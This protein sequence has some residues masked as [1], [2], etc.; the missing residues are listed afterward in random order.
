M[1]K[2]GCGTV[3]LVG[4]V[5]AVCLF[6]LAQAQGQNFM[7]GAGIA[8]V[9]GPAGGMAMMGYVNPLQITKGIH[10]RLRS[11]A[12]VV[13]DPN[14]PSN[15]VVFVSA[16]LGMV[17]GA[18]KT[19]VVEKLANAGFGNLYVREN[20]MLSGIHTHSGPQGF[21]WYTLY[22]VAGFGA[23]E[24]NMD[25]IAEG[26][27]R[28]I[29][30]AHDDLESR[31]GGRIRIG[32]GQLDD[33]NINRSPSAY[34]YNPQWEK[35]LY[36]NN[37]DH[38]MTLLRFEDDNGNP[39][40][41]VNWFSVHG[42]SMNNTNHLISGDNKGTASYLFEKEIDGRDTLPGQKGNF[43]AMFAQ[44]NEGDVSP[45]IE[46]PHCGYWGPPCDYEHSTCPNDKGEERTAGCIARGP[47]NNMFESTFII[48]Q[49]QFSKALEVF[50]DESN[51]R[52]IPNSAIQYCH[53]F[54]DMRNTTV[55]AEFTSTGQVERT[56]PGAIGDATAAGTTDGAG[57]LSFIQG[58]NNTSG[59]ANDFWNNVGSILH[60]PSEEQKL[61]QGEKP[62]FIDTG[63][64]KIPAEWTP[65]VVPIQTF[66]IGDL[67][68]VAVPS[69]LTTMSGRR[70][71]QTV[72]DELAAG[73]LLTDDTTVVIAGLSN[74]YSQYCAT[75]EEYGV[76]RYEGASTLFGP[77]T[78][79]AYQQEFARMTSA[80]TTGTCSDPGPEAVDLR[81]NV[82]QAPALAFSTHPAD[83]FYGDLL[84][85]VKPT[86]K[87][88]EVASAT[89]QAANP[90]GNYM[91]EDTFLKVEKLE[92][93]TNSWVAIRSDGDW[94]T[95]FLWN[96]H[97]NPT[98]STATIEWYIPKDQPAGTY[99]LVYQA[100]YP[101]LLGGYTRPF[102]GISSEFT[103][104]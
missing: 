97:K 78:L 89:F 95:R 12:V 64:V 86:Y 87:A 45:N 9:T 13:A 2:M 15:R 26:I 33:A 7:V 61:C 72:R 70:L 50:N 52:D 36:Q 39:I 16:D 94:D 5:S 96:P 99:R 103:V 46:G 85:D 59:D 31:K 83:S 42:T 66:R 53:S 92:T 93:S 29:L 62:I 38:E 82:V 21:G 28:S 20:V 48:G 51:L 25:M 60:E 32:K 44:T 19:L 71:R 80:M 98:V 100:Y 77:H 1:T 90:S 40:A 91:T 35:D 37:T 101:T 63:S 76:Q 54:I 3:L 74:E 79:A 27:T 81:G 10:F 8:D 102:S 68:I 49:R 41:M 17:F 88:G 23:D 75:Y 22:N 34:E 55:S 47:G 57:S 56:C 6:E 104:E 84:A 30:R 69:E 67:W 73:G 11:R 58:T 43:V 24:R 4:F 18:I 65:N 14:D